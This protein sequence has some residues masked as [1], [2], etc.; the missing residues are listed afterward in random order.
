MKLNYIS[1]NCMGGLMFQYFNEQY[2]NPF[3]WSLILDDKQFVELCINYDKY[4]EESV[5]LK[6]IDEK[7]RWCNDTKK[8]SFNDWEYPILD[9]SGIEIHWIHHQNQEDKLLKN[10]EKRKQRY[11][12]NKTKTIFLFN[13]FTLFQEY[14][15]EEFEELLKT[16]LKHNHY[17]II[18]LPDNLP[19]YI[20]NLSDERNIIVKMEGNKFNTSK[21]NLWYYNENDTPEKRYA[22]ISY[23]EKIK[24]GI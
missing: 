22:F 19:L 9:L 16:F 13:Y 18:L 21:R 17:S 11:L 1:N 7:S 2:T 20:Y 23:I 24:K 6:K 15:L 8:K 10:Y 5:I 4:I 14:T 12:K 3:I